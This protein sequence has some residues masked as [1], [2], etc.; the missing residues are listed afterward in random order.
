MPVAGIVVIVAVV[1]INTKKV[2]LHSIRP[3]KPEHRVRP[4]QGMQV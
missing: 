3:N 1:A 4:F 2:K